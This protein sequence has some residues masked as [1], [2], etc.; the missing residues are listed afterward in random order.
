MT[1]LMQKELFYVSEVLL[2]IEW[3]MNMN[4]LIKDSVADISM[5]ATNPFKNVLKKNIT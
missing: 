5:Y 4:R 3:L 2:L 1:V